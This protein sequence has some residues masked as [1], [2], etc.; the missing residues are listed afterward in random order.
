MRV[1]AATY[2]MILPADFLPTEGFTKQIDELHVRVLVMEKESRLALMAVE[3][4]SLPPEEI[5]ALKAIVCKAS[6]AE[7]AF[8]C[9]TH[10]FSAPHFMPDHQLDDAGKGK[11]AE[12]RKAVQLAAQQA[13]RD[14]AQAM[15]QARLTFGEAACTVNT[16]RDVE[17]S[18][19]WWID[20]NGKGP[21]DH[22]MTTLGFTDEE[23]VRIATLVHYP[24]QSSVLD[25][26]QLREGGKAVSG[27]LAGWMASEVEKQTNAPALFLIGAAG[28]QAP[29]EK[30]VG[31]VVEG[32]ELQ[33][34]DRQDEA[35]EAGHLLAQEMVRAA[36]RA[37]A[38]ERQI[39]ADTL[40][41]TETKVVVPAKKMERDLH[42]L[43]PTRIAPYEA[44]GESTQ[45][46]SLLTIGETRWIG[47]RPEL[48]CVTAQTI[49][50]DDPLSRVITLFDGGAKYMADAASYDR[51][52]YEAMNSP[53]GKGA[54][55]R[56]AAV[57]KVLL[58]NGFDVR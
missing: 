6:G 34:T 16:P 23:N 3:L 31:F 36:F 44:D 9:V 18:M 27:D 47:V 12:L 46:V 56:L 40:T 35:I 17:T 57:A 20:H 54:A 4:T 15:K 14:A 5:E 8:I 11:K 1:G 28:D 2:P 51:I 26:S 39:R 45:P 32:R 58:T 48:N 21:V 24:I 29:R 52:T 25:G 19:G 43:H 10:T 33:R 55:E 22:R 38:G 13:A 50:A 7:K 41:F 37:I 53:F 30:A 42:K 49:T